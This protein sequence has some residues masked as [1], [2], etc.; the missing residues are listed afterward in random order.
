M[1]GAVRVFVVVRAGVVLWF[2]VAF[3]VRLVL[4]CLGFGGLGGCWV[5]LIVVGGGRVLWGVLG[6]G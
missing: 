6:G 5:G 4:V 3:V 1:V 2:G